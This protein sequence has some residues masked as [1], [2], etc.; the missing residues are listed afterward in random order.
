MA[1]L[2]ELLVQEGVITPEQLQQAE[3]HRA[4]HGGNLAQSLIGL[5]LASESDLVRTFAAGVGMPYEDVSDGAVDPVVAGLLPGELARRWTALPV[6]FGEGDEVIVAIAD[7]ASREE[8]AP[9][10]A[11]EMGVRAT[12]ALAPRRALVEAIEAATVDNGASVAEPVMPAPPAPA[13]AAA[14][15]RLT[16][17]LAG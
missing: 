13:A 14:P 2:P 4:Q 16:G 17:T 3:D 15:A 7:P 5:G 1:G 9:L 11:Q 10:L 12:L 6:R 8:L